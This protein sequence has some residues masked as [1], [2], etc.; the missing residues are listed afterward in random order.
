M[1]GAVSFKYR[2]FNSYSHR[3]KAH[4][5]LWNGVRR[6]SDRPPPRTRDRRANPRPNPTRSMPLLFSSDAAVTH[7]LMT[8]RDIPAL[9]RHL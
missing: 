9:S 5:G 1:V 7:T 3:D 4:L 2:A 8:C 6:A